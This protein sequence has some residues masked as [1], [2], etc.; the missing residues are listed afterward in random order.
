MPGK[1]FRCKHCPETFSNPGS[2][3]GHRK[4]IHG[5]RFKRKK[6]NVEGRGGGSRP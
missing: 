3:I 5:E 6:R 4:Q 1:I 2:L